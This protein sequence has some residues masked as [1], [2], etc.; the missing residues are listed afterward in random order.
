M[1]SWK[2]LQ[3]IDVYSQIFDIDK[4]I[5]NFVFKEVYTFFISRVIAPYLINK[6]ALESYFL[7]NIPV[8]RKAEI[9]FVYKMLENIG[10]PG[11]FIKPFVHRETLP[12]SSINRRTHLLQFGDRCPIYRAPLSQ[13]P[14]DSTHATV[15]HKRRTPLRTSLF[16]V[17]DP[18][19]TMY[20]SKVIYKIP[21]LGCDRA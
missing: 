3:D 16:H 9:G 17:K 20:W 19:P 18:V 5:W 2:R 7:V 21:C 10:H 14:E 8:A 12:R 4:N 11:N 13:H 6:G 15:A 1:K